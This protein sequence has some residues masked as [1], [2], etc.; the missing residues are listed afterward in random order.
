MLPCFPDRSRL[1][2]NAESDL[3]SSSLLF[4]SILTVAPLAIAKL[5]D[6]N[7]GDFLILNEL[8][9]LFASIT[10]QAPGIL[11]RLRSTTVLG[12]LA[13][14]VYS[15]SLAPFVP[16]GRIS[17]IAIAIMAGGTVIFGTGL[18]QFAVIRQSIVS[19][20]MESRQTRHST[21]A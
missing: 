3:A 20:E 21:L 8:G 13:S 6:R 4:G 5:I 18:I 16:W 15:V 9:F 19:V 10:L 14:A 7:V 11:F 12:A 2:S 1:T 17:T